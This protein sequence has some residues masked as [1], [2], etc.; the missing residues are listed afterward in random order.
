[1]SKLLK[2]SLPMKVFLSLPH[3]NYTFIYPFWKI[4]YHSFEEKVRDIQFFFQFQSLSWGVSNFANSCK[5]EGATP[6]LFIVSGISLRAS[7]HAAI[8]LNLRHTYTLWVDAFLRAQLRACV[9]ISRT[10]PVNVHL[11]L[12][13]GP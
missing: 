1:M 3:L 10:M 5:G 9:Y 4:P 6:L 2:V 12:W 11:S 7:A 13:E 8:F